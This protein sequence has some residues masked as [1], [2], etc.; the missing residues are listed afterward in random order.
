MN[1]SLIV[2]EICAV[3]PAE[4]STMLIRASIKI[5]ERLLEIEKHHVKASEGKVAVLEDE[6]LLPIV[7][8]RLCVVRRQ[9]KVKFASAEDEKSGCEA[10]RLFDETPVKDVDVGNAMNLGYAQSG[11]F[12]NSLRFSTAMQREN[13]VLATVHPLFDRTTTIM[14]SWNSIVDDYA[15]GGDMASARELVMAHIDPLSWP[16]FW[17]VLARCITELFDLMHERDVVSWSALIDGYVKSGNYKEALAIFERILI[18]IAT[19]TNAKTTLETRRGIG[20]AF[21]STFS[22]GAVMGFLLAASGL[23]GNNVGD[24]VGMGVLDLGEGVNGPIEEDVGFEARELCRDSVDLFVELQSHGIGLDEV[25][26]L[27][28]LSAYAHGSLEQNSRQFDEHGLAPMTENHTCMVVVHSQACQLHGALELSAHHT[29]NSANKSKVWTSMIT[30]YAQNMP[31]KE[32]IR[33]FKKMMFGCV[34]LDGIAVISVLSTCAQLK[35][36]NIGM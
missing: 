10:R 33:F 24:I 18:E 11:L 2:D 20:K 23:L 31:P 28:L 34:K 19:Y 14:V 30:G 7:R 36:L 1:N 6:Q 15:K 16:V 32:A 13:G 29:P 21:I 8:P 27:G 22:S 35:V 5:E 12:V 4:I 3:L 17:I 25:T 26:Y 9:K